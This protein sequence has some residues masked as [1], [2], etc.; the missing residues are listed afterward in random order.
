MW[1]YL[2]LPHT[3]LT[4]LHPLEGP[5]LPI[6]PL[7]PDEITEIVCLPNSQTRVLDPTL[8]LGECLIHSIL[9]VPVR[10]FLGCDLV[11][12]SDTIGIRT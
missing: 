11:F 7:V 2:I 4:S 3:L 6:F 10:F 9:L 12:A 1:P 5:V 8:N